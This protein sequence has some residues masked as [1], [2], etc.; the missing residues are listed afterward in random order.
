M[1]IKMNKKL[2]LKL[3]IDRPQLGIAYRIDIKEIE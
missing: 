2:A 1:V 3:I